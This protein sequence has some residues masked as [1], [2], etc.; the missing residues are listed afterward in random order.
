MVVS[1]KLRPRGSPKLPISRKCLMF[2]NFDLLPLKFDF[3][4]QISAKRCVTEL[5][6]PQFY[7]LVCTQKLRV[8]AKIMI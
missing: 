1:I 6:V 2:G 3:L 8:W 5:H 7:A 4:H